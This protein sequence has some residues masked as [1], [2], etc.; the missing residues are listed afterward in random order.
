MTGQSAAVPSSL[1][2]LET[3]AAGGDAVAM[4]TLGMELL[5][6]GDNGRGRALLTQSAAAGEA[7]ALR[8]LALQDAAEA[9]DAA[10]WTSAFRYLARAAAAG[11]GLAQQELVFLAGDKAAL[12]QVEQGHALPPEAWDNFHAV[13][14]HARLLATPAPRQIMKAPAIHTVPG[15]VPAEV[16]DWIIARSRDR[17]VRAQVFNP[18]DGKARDTVMRTNRDT[19]YPR[20]ELDMVQMVLLRRIG[21]VTGYDFAAMEPTSVLHYQVGEQF[22]QHFDYLDPGAYAQEVRDFGQRVG[23]FLIYL[24]EEFDGGETL[25]PITSYRYK[26]RKGDAL[27]FRNVKP[28]GTPD[29]LTLHA[30]T[31]PTRGEKWLFSQWIRERP[32]RG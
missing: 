14:D 28:D 23:T 7:D 19:R 13:I 12:L 6:A 10:G 1:A 22:R 24:N 5:V 20:G 29:R 2:V 16:C 11:H 15:M 30:G 32:R 9:T 8:Q 18:V 17:L 31:P 27:M 25:F 3:R 26:G 21:A 4:L